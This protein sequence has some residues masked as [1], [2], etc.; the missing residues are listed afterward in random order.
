MPGGQFQLKIDRPNLI[1][2][3]SKETRMDDLIRVVSAKANISGE[4]ARQAVESV[5]A[6]IKDDL[7]GPIGEQVMNLLSGVSG[8]TGQA[9]GA[10]GDVTGKAGAV[11]GDMGNSKI[12]P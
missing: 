5:L 1:T 12:G 7:S 8:Q 9:G 3:V 10:L 6:F 11:S 2:A 4:Q